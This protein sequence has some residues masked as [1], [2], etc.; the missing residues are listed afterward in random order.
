MD[1]ITPASVPTVQSLGRY[2]P[3]EADER[4]ALRSFEA[5]VVSEMLRRAAPK[6]SEGIFD[7]GQAGRMYRDHLYQ[8]Y[9]RVIAENGDFGLA[10][11]L[12]GQLA[13]KEAAQAE[14]IR[15]GGAKDAPA[16]GS[17]AAESPLRRA[18]TGEVGR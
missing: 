7:G 11:Q 3:K 18:P 15:Q 1:G 10:S 13:E 17:A 5:Y 4:T 9:A 12:E 6:E 14:A 8:E 2:V 16:Q